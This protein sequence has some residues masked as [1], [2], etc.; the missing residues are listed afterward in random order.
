MCLNVQVHQSWTFGSSAARQCFIG[1]AITH[2][3]GVRSRSM[4]TWWKA[5]LISFQIYLVSS[6]YHISKTSK[7][8]RYSVAVSVGIYTIVIGLLFILGTLA[9]VRP[10]PQGLGEPTK[11]AL[12]RPPPWP[13]PYRPARTSKP[14]RRPSPIWVRVFLGL[15]D[16]SVIKWTPRTHPDSVFND[17]HM[18]GKIVS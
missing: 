17:P 5:C 18:D 15:Q 1:K 14:S 11:E 3:S 6:Q 4:S 2:P 8:S 16:Q 7:P 10:H 13:P 9:Q 12:G